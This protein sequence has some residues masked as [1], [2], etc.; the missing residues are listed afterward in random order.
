MR[1]LR[2]TRL[3][4]GALADIL[5]S[6]TNFILL[7]FWVYSG[8]ADDTAAQQPWLF[9]VYSLG[10]AASGAHRVKPH[11]TAPQST[12]QRH[13]ERER[14][15]GSVSL[16]SSVLKEPKDFPSYWVTPVEGDKHCVSTTVGSDC[17]V[18]TSEVNYLP[19][20]KLQFV[21]SKYIFLLFIAVC[22]CMAV[23]WRYIIAPCVE[24]MVLQVGLIH[25]CTHNFTLTRLTVAL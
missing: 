17:A 20:T 13:R 16:A 3:G 9:S 6:S 24:D 22:C 19:P 15:T 23:Y 14:E 11:L 25:L 2:I 10:S 12:T 4:C 5:K 18:K 21:F 7:N 1:T 8:D